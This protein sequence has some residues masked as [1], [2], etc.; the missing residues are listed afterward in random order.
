MIQYMNTPEY[1]L[2]QARYYFDQVERCITGNQ[3]Q[4]AQQ[5]HDAGSRIMEYLDCYMSNS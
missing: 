3:L 5:Y 2:F 4:Q 1:L